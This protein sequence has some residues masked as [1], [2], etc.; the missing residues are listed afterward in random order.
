TLQHSAYTLTATGDI[1]EADEDSCFAL[2]V[3]DDGATDNFQMLAQFYHR[4]QRYVACTPLEP[5]LFFAHRTANRVALL[6]PE[7]FERLQP[8]IEDQ[9]FEGLD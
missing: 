6:S 3:D 9:L 8:Q 2:E 7:E 1:P 5:L 4:E